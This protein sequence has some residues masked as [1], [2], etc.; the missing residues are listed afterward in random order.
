MSEI[1]PHD[2]VSNVNGKRPFE[3]DNFSDC[4]DDESNPMQPR[5]EEMTLFSQEVFE[6]YLV[7]WIVGNNQPFSQVESE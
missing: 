7:D 3:W 1:T 2:S 4:E 6:E 5:M